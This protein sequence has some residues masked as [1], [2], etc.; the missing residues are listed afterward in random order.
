MLPQATSHCGQ[1]ILPKGSLLNRMGPSCSRSPRLC[2]L[3]ISSSKFY[4]LNIKF[5]RLRDLKF[6]AY[7]AQINLLMCINNR[8][9]L[10][11]DSGVQLGLPL[12]TLAFSSPSR[13]RIAP[14]AMASSSN[15]PG[16]AVTGAIHEHASVMSATSFL[17]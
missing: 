9:T 5:L 2:K 16:Y 12:Y 3:A 6:E 11:N 7:K 8:Y 10:Y 13:T 15:S 14:A 17:L 1:G 4:R